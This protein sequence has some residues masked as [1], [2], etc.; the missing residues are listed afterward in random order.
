MLTVTRISIRES[1]EVPFWNFSTE[2]LAKI[3]N[4]YDDTGKRVSFTETL[5]EDGLIQTRITVWADSTAQ[6][7]YDVEFTEYW[8]ER[9]AYNTDHQITSVCAFERP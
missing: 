2:Q 5:S 4:T 8:K 7:E 6:Q 9:D 1:T 3:K